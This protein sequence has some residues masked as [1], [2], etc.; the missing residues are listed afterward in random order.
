[1]KVLIAKSWELIT[2]K[3]R[4]PEGKLQR[5]NSI[6]DRLLTIVYLFLK[7]S[8]VVLNEEFS[9]FGKAPGLP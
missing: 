1:M 2:P 4:G 9:L 7:H 6:R 5:S 8:T 3:N